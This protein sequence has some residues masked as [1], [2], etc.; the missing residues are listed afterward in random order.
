MR[1]LGYS[2]DLGHVAW[3]VGFLCG[4]GRLLSRGSQRGLRVGGGGSRGFR[5]EF[6]MAVKGMAGRE[7]WCLRRDLIADP[8]AVL[9]AAGVLHELS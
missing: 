6:C 8:C 5:R 7:C 9:T 3:Q 1:L 2:Q 4:S